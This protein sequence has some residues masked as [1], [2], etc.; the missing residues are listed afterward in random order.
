MPGK[1]VHTSLSL[2][3]P[4][5]TPAYL[6]LFCCIRSYPPL[7]LSILYTRLST[8]ILQYKVPGVREASLSISPS[9]TLVYLLLSCSLRCQ[10]CARHRWN[11]RTARTPNGPRASSPNAKCRMTG[12]STRQSSS[13]CHRKSRFSYYRMCSLMIE[14]FSYDRMCSLTIECVLL[15]TRASGNPGAMAAGHRQNSC[16]AGRGVG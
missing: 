5:Y 1:R 2:P 10:V 12:C 8:F 11:T 4:Y 13:G 16:G 14:M 15:H 6:H 7:S 9:Y 3:S